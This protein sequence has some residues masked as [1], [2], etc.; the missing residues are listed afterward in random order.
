VPD[1]VRESGVLVLSEL[2]TNALVHARTPF[3][4][5]AEYDAGDLSLAVLDGDVTGPDLQPFDDGLRVGGRGMAIVDEVGATWGV[6]TTVLGKVVWA[7]IAS[8]AQVPEQRG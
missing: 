5:W 3:L 6:V 4:V 1:D 2:V 8:S 7:T